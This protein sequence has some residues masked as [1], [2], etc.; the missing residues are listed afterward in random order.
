MSFNAQVGK[1]FFEA[2]GVVAVLA[3][4]CGFGFAKYTQDK[5]H[6]DMLKIVATMHTFFEKYSVQAPDI[7]KQSTVANGAKF[8][9]TYGLMD[10][11]K[12]SPSFFNKYQNVCAFELGEVDVKTNIGADSVQTEVFVHFF[13]MYKKHSCRQFLAVGW[14]KVL[15]KGWWKS[16]SYIGV[17]SENTNGKMYFSHNSNYIRN[18]GA[19]EN[20]TQQHLKNVCDTCKGSRYCSILFSF[21]LDD[22]VLKHV[23]F[24]AEFTGEKEKPNE[25]NEKVT[26]KGSTYTKT[27][28][29]VKEVV[30]YGNNNTFKGVTYTGGRITSTYQGTYSPRGITSYVSHDTSGRNRST[31][32]NISYDKNGKVQGYEKGSKKIFLT[33]NAQDCLI[34]D[35][36]N[37]AKKFANCADLFHDEKSSMLLQYDGKGFLREIVMDGAEK[38]TYALKYDEYTGELTDYCE[39]NGKKCHKVSK[40]KTLKDIVKRDIPTSVEKFEPLWK[41]NG[42]NGEGSQRRVISKDEIARRVKDQG[43]SIKIIMK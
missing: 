18:D 23:T 27:S 31:I 14:E 24:P 12:E 21:V 28:G 1:S 43:N 10:E 39:E 36:A 13:D 34:M 3:C 41:Q 11:C 25:K 37:N 8:I 17:V 42:K 40:G 29:N 5:H 2:F 20:P 32:N 7:F 4:V 35:S 15:P 38:K 22:D 19:Q 16:E 30:T 33:G 9:K 6:E 26:K